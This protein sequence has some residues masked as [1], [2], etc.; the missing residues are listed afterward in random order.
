MICWFFAYDFLYKKGTFY[1]KSAKLPIQ[2]Y[3]CGAE[4]STSCIILLHLVTKLIFQSSF[5]SLYSMRLKKAVE[6]KDT[7]Y[8]PCCIDSGKKLLPIPHTI[9]LTQVHT[10]SFKLSAKITSIKEANNYGENYT[11][12]SV[13][14][15]KKYAFPAH[16]LTYKLNEVHHL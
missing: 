11:Q 6:E 9:Y 16:A 12:S 7:V 10:E 8:Q 3:T 1:R 15:I 5:I 14:R 4:Q 2:K 13:K